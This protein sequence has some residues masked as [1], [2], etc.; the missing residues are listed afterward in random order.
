MNPTTRLSSRTVPA[1]SS[2]CCPTGLGP[3]AYGG[4]NGPGMNWSLHALFGGP[5]LD[6]CYILLNPNEV[7]FIS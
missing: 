2:P 3:F 5:N 1:D 7:N 4:E 6:F